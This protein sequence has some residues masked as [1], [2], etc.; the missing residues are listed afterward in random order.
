VRQRRMERAAAQLHA[1]SSV[2][3]AASAA[4][5]ACPRCFADAFRRHF[6]TVPS[7][8]T[9]AASGQAPARTV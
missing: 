4:G 3:R 8:M 2:S 7:A 9:R 6:G 1:G 5:Y